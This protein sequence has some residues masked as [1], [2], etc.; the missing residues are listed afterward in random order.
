MTLYDT[1]N[2]VIHYPTVAHEVYDVSGAGDTVI[3]TLGIMLANKIPIKQAV[4]VA[5]I[6]AGLVIAKVGTATVTKNEL[7]NELHSYKL[8][9]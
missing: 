4:L 3:A 5:N 7:I 6:A 8:S 1:N 9:T 2:Q